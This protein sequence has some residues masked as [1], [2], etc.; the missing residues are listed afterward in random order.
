MRPALLLI[1]FAGLAATAWWWFGTAGDDDALEDLSVAGD[2]SLLDHA[3]QRHVDAK[4]SDRIDS[5]DDPAEQEPTIPTPSVATRLLVRGQII[6]LSAKVKLRLR[7]SP[8]ES[9]TARLRTRESLL[10]LTDEDG[11]F[12]KAFDLPEG[13]DAKASVLTASLVN[14]DIGLRPHRYSAADAKRE[15][16]FLVFELALSVKTETIIC[17]RVVDDE[18]Q[19]LPGT[20][21][22]L[23]KFKDQNPVSPDAVAEV[24]SDAKGQFRLIAPSETTLLVMAAPTEKLPASIVVSP[25]AHQM[26]RVGDLRCMPA[27]EVSGIVMFRGNPLAGIKVAAR[28]KSRGWGLV[29][30]GDHFRLY[31]WQ[32]GIVA[33]WHKLTT[34]DSMGRFEIKGLSAETYIVEPGLT[35]GPFTLDPSQPETTTWFHEDSP[36]FPLPSGDLAHLV[37]SVIDSAQRETIAPTRGLELKIKAALLSVEVS[38]SKGPIDGAWIQL[39]CD[40]QEPQV[41]ENKG[42]VLFVVP[43]GP[44]AIEASHG[45]CKTEVCKIR[46]AD[47]TTLNLVKF[48]MPREQRADVKLT[49]LDGQGTPVKA[50]T[51]SFES[52]DQGRLAGLYS[53]AKNGVH[54]VKCLR[55]GRYSVTV[56][57]KGKQPLVSQETLLVVPKSGQ[58]EQTIRLEVGARLRVG[59]RR[60]G[61]FV[62]RQLRIR[63]VDGEFIA[64]VVQC[65]SP[66][67]V[68]HTFQGIAPD[69]WPCL[70]D[71]KTPFS[72]GQYEIIFGDKDEGVHRRVI[73]LAAND[74]K[75]VIIDL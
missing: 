41:T 40:P 62:A 15:G 21:V 8:D 71:V 28:A 10:L 27:L 5:G 70:A 1:L 30:E 44:L 48:T 63:P 2:L 65:R 23:F 55:A 38:D 68:R 6:G 3:P 67:G 49:V 54:L 69:L 35:G 75:D 16:K 64:L 50:V 26:T 59:I 13:F 33:P 4:V 19:P 29:M 14:S 25:T 60:N 43:I 42:R 46:I 36:A 22:G 7:F 12:N 17:G 74:T 53:H 61:K 58:V 31:R 56:R 32:D 73:G 47:S 51:L 45:L 24:K 11:T 20:S 37:N 57:S 34:T 9:S 66:D 72:P 18:G 52:R 39:D